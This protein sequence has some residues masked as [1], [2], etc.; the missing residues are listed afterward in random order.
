MHKKT[1]LPSGCAKLA[2]KLTLVR[3][4]TLTVQLLSHVTLTVLLDGPIKAEI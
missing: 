2:C 1:G 4:M 3:V